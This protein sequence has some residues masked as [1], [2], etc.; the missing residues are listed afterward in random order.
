MLAS[1]QP[2]FMAWG[3]ARTWLYNDAFIPILAA[4]HPAALGRHALE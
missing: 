1:P 3:P 2:M 4:K